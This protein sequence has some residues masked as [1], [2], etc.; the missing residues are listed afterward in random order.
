MWGGGRHP[1]G[2]FSLNHTQLDDFSIA[3]HKIITQQ[4][5]EDD[6]QHAGSLESKALP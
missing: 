4:I 5:S 2:Y 3:G 1:V 6:A